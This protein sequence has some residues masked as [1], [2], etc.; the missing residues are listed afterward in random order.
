[1]FCDPGAGPMGQCWPVPDD[2][3]LRRDMETAARN[4]ERIFTQYNLPYDV[5]PGSDLAAAIEMQLRR[6][7]ERVEKAERRAELEK[8]RLKRLER[9]AAGVT[10]KV[11]LLH[12][13]S[14]HSN[15]NNSN[16][17]IMSISSDFCQCQSYY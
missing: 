7:I 14:S 11:P 15:N 3:A 4:H 10:D 2:P 6:E 8:R 5:D 12:L 13:T 16:I 17:F 9:K 1:M